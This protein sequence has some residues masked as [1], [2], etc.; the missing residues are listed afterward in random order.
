MR[1]LVRYPYYIRRQPIAEGL[2]KEI[3]SRTMP[4]AELRKWVVKHH[5]H[6]R[7]DVKRLERSKN[8]KVKEFLEEMKEAGTHE[9]ERYDKKNHTTDA[10]ECYK[11]ADCDLPGDETDY[12]SM[13]RVWREI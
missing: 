1:R 12:W 7:V 3:Y 11:N 10:S 5:K 8:K 6:L 9:K 2:I 4:D 13:G